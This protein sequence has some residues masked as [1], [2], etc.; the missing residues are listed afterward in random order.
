MPVLL[1]LLLV[2]ALA[3]GTPAATAGVTKTTR[4]TAGVV[5][6]QTVPALGGVQV[7][8]GSSV[9]TTG[10]DGFASVWVANL[11]DTASRVSLAST[12]LDARTTVT[13]GAVT[14][15]AVH[16]KHESHLS[17][18][19]DVTSQVTLRISGG[20]TGVAPSSV[21]LVR[22]HSLTG[23][24]LLVA[25]G[26]TPTVR[27]LSR[28]SRLIAGVV[29]SQ[30]VTWSVDSLQASPGV[31]ITTA[32]GRFDPYTSATWPLVLRPVRGTVIVDTVPATP[33][34]T[35][36]L[37]GATFTTD[38]RGR[39]TGTSGDLNDVDRRL[40]LGTPRAGAA[41]VAILAVSRLRAA[42]SFQRHVVAALSVRRPVSLSFADTAGRPVPASRITRI[43]LDR[44][45][46]SV[47]FASAE[48]AAP[49]LLLSDQP[50]FVDGAWQAQQV[51]YSV[52][53]VTLE[54]A[55]AVFA[56]QQRFNP[57]NASTWPISL[58]VFDVGITVRDVLFG[59]QV[60]SDAWVTRPDGARLAVQLDDGQPTIL[61]S[62]VRGP[63]TVTLQS[64]VVGANSTFLVSRDS[65]VQLRIVTPTDT[66]VLLLLLGGTAAS[67]LL[68][69]RW[70]RRRATA[71]DQE[72]HA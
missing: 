33:G 8:V 48:L 31:S 44:T 37:D 18:G 41:T 51:T 35:F 12:T 1:A 36:L 20:A 70:W 16:A 40:R 28:K 58:S 10:P 17:V 26:R 14:P 71:H 53:S 22:L 57:S 52:A 4:A 61:R 27:L 39:A 55:D 32:P 56:G 59:R 13:L 42:A 49:L 9:V 30:V 45:G 72:G 21:R 11:N 29:T 54:G 24:T 65:Q 67:V 25:P 66:L 50:R 60:A 69:G 6:I 38:S 47:T 68:L 23:Q 43:Q 2:A 64:A 19:L 5:A 3:T 34:V 15:A 7:Q 63:Y 46:G 62:L